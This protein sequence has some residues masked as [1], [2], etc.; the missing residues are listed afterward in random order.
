[1]EAM[2]RHVFL[3][4]SLLP[5]ETARLSPF[6]HGFTVGD[7]VFES[8][9]TYEGRPFA[10]R[11]HFTRLQRSAAIMG[12][13]TPSWEIVEAAVAQ[14][15][16]ANAAT[17]AR[18]R[19][20]LTRGEAPLGSEQGPHA[21]PTLCV[22][23]AELPQRTPLAK[24]HLVPW[25]RN[26]RSALQQVKST[27]Y[28]EN[29][30]ALAA[31]HACGAQEAIFLNTQGHLCE[32]SGSNLF[33]VHQGRLHTPSVTSGC[34]DGITRGIVMDLAASLGIAVDESPLTVE[35]LFAADEAFLTSTFREV[36]A[37]S[38]VDDHPLPL[39]PLTPRLQAAFRTA[40]TTEMFT[41]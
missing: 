14:V 28:A 7:G 33:L 9:I 30:V 10:L 3:N 13:E 21:R 31:A 16:K 11:R 4:G 29:V 39:G 35:A 20:T 32:G 23:S 17:H 6:D 12:L 26:E 15:I 5:R 37:I 25:T 36:Q 24:I 41:D 40:V 1:M 34:L 19:L 38:H 27:S 18:L 2:H 22:A 8:I